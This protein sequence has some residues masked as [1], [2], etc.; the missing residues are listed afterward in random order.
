MKRYVEASF[1]IL[2]LLVLGCS[3]E[4]S[5]KEVFSKR[6][7]FIS[8]SFEELSLGMSEED[9][10]KNSQFYEMGER[11]GLKTYVV[12]AHSYALPRQVPMK[13]L[14]NIRQ[15]FCYFFNGVLSQ[16]SIY[17]FCNYKFDPTWD[18]FIYNA[19]QKYGDGKENTITHKVKWDDGKTTLIIEEEF[20]PSRIVAGLTDHFYITTYIDNE[21]SRKVG[22]R[23]QE[24]SPQF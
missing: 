19:K 24:L 3:K 9:F 7:G 14:D 11:G 1:V 23:E 13:E 2:L 16:F 8:R 5:S 6:Q 22:Q 18:N 10:R 4:S 15:V 20:E 12:Y 21:I 17:Y